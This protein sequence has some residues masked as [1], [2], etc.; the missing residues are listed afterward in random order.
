MKDLFL[1][2]T[3]KYFDEIKSG[4][5][6]EEYRL[7]TSYW[8][9]KIINKNYENIIFQLGYNKKNRVIV[10]Y[11]GFELKN[12]K[13]DFFGNDEISVFALKLGDIIS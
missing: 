2:V 11:L 1:I 3:K 9:K 4:S 13:H 12:I 8:I 7:I 5:K 6:K 10:K